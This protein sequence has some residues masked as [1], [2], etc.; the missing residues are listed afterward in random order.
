MLFVTASITLAPASTWSW[1]C[2][3]MAKVHFL[4]DGFNLYHALDWSG[5][6]K[7]Q[8]R[9]RK[10]KWISFAKLANC[11]ITDRKNDSVAGIEFFTTLPHWDPAKVLRHKLFIKVQENEGVKV[12]YGVF[13]RKEQKCKLCDRIFL[14]YAEKQTDVNIAVRLF[15]L[16]VEG[17]FDKAII[18]S[19]DTD[20]I[21]VV[22][23]VQALFPSKPLGVV[24]P[25]G[26][27]SEEFKN[28]ADFHYRMKEKHLSSSELPDTVTLKDGS[29]VARPPNWK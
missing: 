13:K 10:Y 11:Y 25:I 24:I 26:R 2:Y 27:S 16:A 9:Y 7:D 22:K 1:V 17:K 19:G 4:I 6:A 18:V 8:R 12:V 29:T 5:A 14:T 21:P 3:F 20:L 28:Q 15:Q 23:A